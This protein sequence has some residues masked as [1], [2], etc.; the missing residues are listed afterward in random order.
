MAND[1]PASGYDDAV[2]YNVKLTRIVTYRGAQLQ[3]LPVHEMTGRVLK[4]IILDEGD[5]VID[6]AD[7]Q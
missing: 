2:T 6:R 3:P 4:A 7:P 1:Q 5:D